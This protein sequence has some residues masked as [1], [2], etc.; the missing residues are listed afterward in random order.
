MA[1]AQHIFFQK[2]HVEVLGARSLWKL[3]VQANWWLVPVMRVN[4][5]ERPSITG[6]HWVTGLVWEKL[7]CTSCRLLWPSEALKPVLVNKNNRDRKADSEVVFK[8]FWHVAEN[9]NAGPVLYCVAKRIFKKYGQCQ[10]QETI[11]KW[12]ALQI[13]W[14]YL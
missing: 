12:F 10:R 7:W 8:G 1:L 4:F 11:I 6:V 3:Q 5:T 13:P 9:S 14:K 2:H